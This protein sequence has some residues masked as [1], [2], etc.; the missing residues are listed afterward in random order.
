MGSTTSSTRKGKIPADHISN[1]NVVATTSAMSKALM[2]PLIL[3]KIFHNLNVPDLK[4]CRLVS[5]AWADHGAALLGNR[6][7]F[8]VNELV[9]YNSGSKLCLSTPLI[10]EKLVRR[11]KFYDGTKLFGQE[12]QGVEVITNGLRM[13][14]SKEIQYVR[15]KLEKYQACGDS[16]ILQRLLDSAPNLTILDVFASSFP[17]LERCRNLKSLKFILENHFNDTITVDN[18]TALLRQVKDSLTEA[19]LGWKT[20][21]R[22]WLQSQN[23]SVP[24]MSKLTSLAIHP[25]VGYPI[26]D[27]FNEIY[28]PALEK[29]AFRNLYSATSL[30]NHLVMWQRHRGV[31]LAVE[32]SKN[33]WQDELAE[34]IIQLFPNVR[35][36]EIQIKFP[37]NWISIL[38]IN[39]MM[40]PFQMWELD[41]VDVDVE[42]EG[43]PALT[44]AILKNVS[45]WKDMILYS[46]GLR[47]LKF[48]GD[49]DVPQIVELMPPFS[50]QS[51]DPT[52]LEIL[53]KLQPI[54]LSEELD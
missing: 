46:A 14:E 20:Y 24:I 2:N 13:V 30:P 16:K 50:Q 37:Y 23:M 19:E 48:S 47:S 7:Y 5:H 44:V 1:D 27:F 25:F 38:D 18:T 12:Y 34:S 53:E 17:D 11:L 49:K 33:C 45:L 22:S 9:Y 3:D 51:G 32:L 29:L 26:P 40:Q 8:N 21:L 35:K 31:T 43:N 15:L 28:L 4:S 39:Q 36:F 10:N 41:Q 54:L 42:S 52:V 6:S